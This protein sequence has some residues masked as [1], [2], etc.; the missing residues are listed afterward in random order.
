[1][2]VKA[3]ELLHGAAKLELV[4]SARDCR[5]DASMS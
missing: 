3:G 2:S 5:M 1:M 4:T